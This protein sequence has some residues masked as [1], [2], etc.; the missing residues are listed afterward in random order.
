MS[1]LLQSKWHT[2]G[3][4][5]ISLHV[6]EEWNIGGIGG[7]RDDGY[8]RLQDADLARVEIKWAQAEGF[9]VADRGTIP[10]NIVDAYNEAHQK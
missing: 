1:N 10:A 6:P 8:L 7:T 4:Q 2:V 3:W 5:G 9:K